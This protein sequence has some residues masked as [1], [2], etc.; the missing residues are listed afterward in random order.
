MAVTNAAR[1]VTQGR[2]A[3]L[4]PGSNRVIVGEVIAERLGLS[5][6]DALTVL[7][8]AVTAGGAPTP[9]LRNLTVAGA[10]EVGRTEHDGTLVFANIDDVKA[11]MREAQAGRDCE[12]VFATRCRRPP[13]RPGCVRSCPPGFE[14]FDWTQDNAN[15]FVP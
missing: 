15:Y 14:L 1:S 8:P 11:M 6:G 2:L 5:L 12:S 7:V 10:F 13:W 4:S 9:K 3:D